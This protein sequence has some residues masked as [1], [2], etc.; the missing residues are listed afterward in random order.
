MMQSVNE[1]KYIWQS[2][3]KIHIILNWNI[4]QS[5]TKQNDKTEGDD[6]HLYFIISVPFKSG[7]KKSLRERE[8]E[9]N[10]CVQCA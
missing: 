6:L 10:E 9:R 2:N 3:A 1:Y 7:M 5:K 8:R 4:K